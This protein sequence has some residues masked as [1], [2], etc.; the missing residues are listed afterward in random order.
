MTIIE[1][2]HDSQLFGGLAPFRNLISWTRWLAFF[3]A[4]TLSVEHKSAVLLT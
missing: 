4:F 1:A 3:E 2:L